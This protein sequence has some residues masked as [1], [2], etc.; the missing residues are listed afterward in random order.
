MNEW[1]NQEK[2]KEKKSQQ[3]KRN[4]SGC[5]T[6]LR[7]SCKTQLDRNEWHP[8]PFGEDVV[9]GPPYTKTPKRPESM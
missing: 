1:S 8:N 4:P 7:L 3:S 5:Q 6:R 2:I 9:K